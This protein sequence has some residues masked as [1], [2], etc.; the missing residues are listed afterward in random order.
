[1]SWAELDQI[2][3]AATDQAVDGLIA[4]N[5]TLARAGLNDCNRHE[6]GGLSGA[7]LARRSNEVIAHIYRQVGHELPVIGVGGV[8][9]PDDV[10]AKLGAGDV[11]V[12]VYTG[13]VYQ[14]PRLAGNLLR[15]L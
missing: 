13:L 9:S 1:M 5:T 4:T 8:S 10:K 3:R 15:A 6:K 7:P 2:L 11:L 14:G 12:Q